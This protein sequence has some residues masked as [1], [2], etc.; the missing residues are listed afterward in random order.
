[1]MLDDQDRHK[2]REWVGTS[3]PTD[4][5]LD[6]IAVPFTYWQEVA[7][8][9]LKQRRATLASGEMVTNFTLSGVLSTGLKAP[10]AE[11][12]N[13]AIAELERQLAEIHGEPVST[14]VSVTRMRRTDR[15]R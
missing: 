9:V 3:S 15:V 5:D 7:L 6:D 13:A 2:V 11:L 10:D 12:L 4:D 8:R 1:M 14:G